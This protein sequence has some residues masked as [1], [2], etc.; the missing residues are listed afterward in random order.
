MKSEQ[1]QKGSSE[2][3]RID[4]TM[5]QSGSIAI[6]QNPPRSNENSEQRQGVKR[7]EDQRQLSSHPRY[8]RNDRRQNYRQQEDLSKRPR[9]DDPRVDDYMMDY[10]F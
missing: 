10:K 5:A 9:I 1:D 7:K 6:A 8:E 3:W 2:L 4:K